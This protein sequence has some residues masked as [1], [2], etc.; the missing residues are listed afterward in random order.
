MEGETVTVT[1]WDSE[2]SEEGTAGAKVLRVW[3]R[4]E[5]SA[6]VALL[7]SDCYGRVKDC[8]DLRP[9]YE[10]APALSPKS[11]AYI[12]ES[13]PHAATPGSLQRCWQITDTT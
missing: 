11:T 2:P 6:D 12:A 4:L 13:T 9:F 8:V 10:H 1:W 3:L 5:R 7:N